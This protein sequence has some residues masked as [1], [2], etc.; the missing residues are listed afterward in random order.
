MFVALTVYFMGFFV[1]VSEWL[2]RRRADSRFSR[3]SEEDKPSELGIELTLSVTD[4]SAGAIVTL[5]E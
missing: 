3:E 5:W 1:V 2:G 4:S